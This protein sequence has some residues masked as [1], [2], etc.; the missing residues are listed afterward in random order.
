MKPY[1]TLQPDSQCG[2]RKD[3][4]TVDMILEPCIFRRIVRNRIVHF[5]F[6]DLTRV[7]TRYKVGLN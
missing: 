6:N 7:F 1:D 2:L 5:S 4:E 3:R